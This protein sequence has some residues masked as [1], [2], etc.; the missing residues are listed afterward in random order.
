[1]SS[2]VTEAYDRKPKFSLVVMAPLPGERRKSSMLLLCLRNWRSK[3]TRVRCMGAAA[4]CIAGTCR[5][6]RELSAAIERAHPEPREGAPAS[7]NDH[8]LLE[9]EAA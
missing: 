6:A 8:D 3:W 9:D 7:A 4:N 1:V 2:G 5:H